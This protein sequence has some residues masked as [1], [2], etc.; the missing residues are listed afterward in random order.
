MRSPATRAGYKEILDE[1]KGESGL[2]PANEEDSVVD[3]ALVRWMNQEFIR[4]ARSWRGERLLAALMAIH[5]CFSRIGSRKLP[6]AFRALKEWRVLSPPYS[7]V[8][9]DWAV[10]CALAIEMARDGNFLVGCY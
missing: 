5:S 2:E 1:F 9:E 10:W 4:G 8:P 6:R 7:R 3:D